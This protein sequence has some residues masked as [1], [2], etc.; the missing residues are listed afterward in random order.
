MYLDFEEMR[1]QSRIWVYQANRQLSTEEVQSLEEGLRKFTAQW[2]AHGKPLKSSGKVYHNQFLVIAVD[3]DFNVATGCSIDSSVAFVREAERSLNINFFDRSK[4]AF[5]IDE[6][7]YLESLPAL[8]EKVAQGSITPETKTFNNLVADK[9][10][11]EQ[12]WVVAAK[13]SWLSRYF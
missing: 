1:P 5:L 11:L 12:E 9:A 10:A 13:D 3:E 8:K 7:I 2:E 6:Q 4:V